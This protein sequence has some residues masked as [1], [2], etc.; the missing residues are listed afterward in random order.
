MT[1]RRLF[2][3]AGGPASVAGSASPFI[4]GV[5]FGVSGGGNWFYGYYWWWITGM[6]P[7]VECALWCAA[8]TAHGG[9]GNVFIP[10]SE[11]TSGTLQPGW[12]FIPLATP[13]QL[14]ASYDPG[15]SVSG[16]A[17]VAAVA[18]NGGFPATT[19]QFNAGDPFAA[20]IT[21]GPLVAY[22]GPTGSI[23]APYSLGQGLFTVAGSDP[24]TNMPN[25]SD[26]SGDGAT[27]FWV[28]VAIGGPPAGFTGPYWTDGSKYDASPD[29]TGDIGTT[30]NLARQVNLTQACE[31]NATTFFSPSGASGLPTRCGV[32]SIASQAEIATIASPAWVKRADGSPAAAGDGAIMA[33]WPAGTV[34]PAGQ[35]RV[36]V[37]NANGALGTWSLK[38]AGSAPYVTGVYSAGTVN[39]PLVVPNLAAAAQANV[40]QGSGTTSGQP[41]FAVT[42][43]AYPDETTG[44][45]PNQDYFV[46][47]A[48]SPVAA[49]SGLPYDYHHREYRR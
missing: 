42:A 46:G 8:P 1:V 5:T 35:Y 23:P 37:G 48:A 19:S 24:T 28:D 4:A 20:G 32:W 2:A 33:L 25:Q 30:Y 6:S 38:D 12:N 18:A 17:Y 34:L 21:S 40:Y 16:S 43:A 49:L 45:S 7:T 15:S 14:A 27:N 29:A 13:L 39:G 3:S 36:A 22:S 26:S 10:G 47:L 31:L 41:S 44:A 11:V 9:T